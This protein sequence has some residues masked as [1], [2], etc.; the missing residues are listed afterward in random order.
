MQLSHAVPRVSARFD[1]A[2]L[3]AAAGLVPVMALAARAG[4]GGLVSRRC[5]VGSPNAAGKVLALI[6]GMAAGADCVDDMDLLRH[7]GMG[8]LFDGVRAPSTLGTFLRSFTFGHVRQLDSIASALLAVLVAHTPVLPA[9][10]GVVLVDFDDTM[11]AVHGYA[12]QGAGY[13]YSGVKGLNAL[14]AC[15]STPT[16]KYRV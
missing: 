11:R 7:G 6:A 16:V 14:L 2:N 4:L 10:A 5:T 1:D 13:G 8:R 3:V 9:D 12:K 15:A